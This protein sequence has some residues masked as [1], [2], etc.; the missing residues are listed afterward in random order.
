M[1]V[2]PPLLERLQAWSRRLRR[3]RQPDFLIGDPAEPYLR[4]WWV[5][6]RNR[7]FNIY[8]HEVLKSDDDRALHDHPWL[9]CSLILIGGYFEHGIR[10]GGVHERK[11]RGEGS[12]T[13]RSARA[14]HRLEVPRSAGTRT[15][16]LFI[17]GPIIRHWGFHC[18]TAGW[19]HWKDFTG[20]VPK[21]QVGRG[22]GELDAPPLKGG[23]RS[24]LRPLD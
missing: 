17:T 19:R 5:I 15:V 23:W 24:P 13:L 18:P 20:P 12:V 4:R 1:R 21:G 2:P 11:W 10:A 14:A 22:C 3:S 16:T 6:P 7:W 8:L 9:N